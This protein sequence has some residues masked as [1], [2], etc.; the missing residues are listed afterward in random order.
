ML[1]L[2]L[3]EWANI[4]LTLL[5]VGT[6]YM[7]ITLAYKQRKFYRKVARD[8]VEWPWTARMSI[9]TWLQIVTRSTRPCTPKCEYRNSRATIAYITLYSRTWS[10]D[11]S[12]RAKHFCT[13]ADQCIALVTCC[14]AR[15]R[16]WR[17]G[18]KYTRPFTHKTPI[19]L[20]IVKRVILNT[21]KNI[22]WIH[23]YVPNTNKLALGKTRHFIPAL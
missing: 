2:I 21:W 9:Y 14:Q 10:P 16:G 1:I 19:Y 4:I 23:G 7:Y 18:T 12:I 3:L 15:P 11:S 6:D 20:K 17:V 8:A 22:H 13:S 5:V